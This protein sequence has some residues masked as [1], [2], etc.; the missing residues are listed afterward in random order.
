MTCVC[1]LG[2][3]RESL[4]TNE[5]LRSNDGGDCVTTLRRVRGLTWP[6][7]EVSGYKKYFLELRFNT[8]VTKK[9]TAMV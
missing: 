8:A 7:M 6:V 2:R 1:D 3:F 5:G 4:C 9:M